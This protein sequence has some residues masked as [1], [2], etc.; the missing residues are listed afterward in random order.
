[1]RILVGATAITSAG[2]AVQLSTDSVGRVLEFTFSAPAANAAIVYW[3]HSSEISS[4]G[5]YSMSSATNFPPG[6]QPF[7]FPAKSGITPSNFWMNASGST[8]AR[9]RHVF[10]VEP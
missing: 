4:V 8:T 1:M 9:I 6:G 3:G 7:T 2:S 5:S 10:V